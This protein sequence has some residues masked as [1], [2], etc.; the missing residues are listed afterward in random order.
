MK[1]RKVISKVSKLKLMQEQFGKAITF[2]S[3]EDSLDETYYIPTIIPSFNRASIIGGMPTGCVSVIHGPYTEGKSIFC[4]LIC[5][6]FLMKNHM[7]LYN[8]LEHTVS[9]P[10]F[11]QLSVNVNELIY[12]RCK[13][14]EDYADYTETIIDKFKNLK[15]AGVIEPETSLIIVWDSIN[16]VV[17]KNEYK[18]LLKD[19]SEALDKGLERTRARLF[20][21]WLDHMTPIIGEDNINL[22]C[23]AQEREKQTSNIWE[24]DFK[25]K[26]PQGVMYDAAVRIRIQTA[27]K[28]WMEKN[29]KKFIVGQKHRLTVF[30]NKVGHP[31][32]SGDF[33][34][35]NGKGDAPIGY[36]LAQTCFMEAVKHSNL[37]DQTG[38]WYRY[39]NHKWQGISQA[40]SHLRKDKKL[41]R[42]LLRE[43]NERTF[44]KSIS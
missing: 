17:P 33:Y 44:T 35:S 9:K 24:Q 10:W 31:Y 22:C 40:L 8:D 13:Y 6:S 36:D 14:F 7:A 30:K 18:R 27:K 43:L 21:A 23:I 29:K 2:D 42:K 26:G 28:L 11:V 1:T 41:L 19:G 20:Q 16:K 3:L 25:I 37:I 39:E 15:Q 5:Q 38:T 34:I 32:E 12:K 4:A